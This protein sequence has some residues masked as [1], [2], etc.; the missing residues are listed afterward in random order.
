MALSLCIGGVIERSE[1]MH[2]MPQEFS[3][4]WMAMTFLMIV[5]VLLGMVMDPFGAVILVSAT[6][7]PGTADDIGTLTVQGN[8]IGAGGMLQTRVAGTP[9]APV[10][11]VLQISGAGNTASGSTGVSVIDAANF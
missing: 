4:V 9:Q 8:Y 7:A 5:K 10:A 2:L 3:S 6:I 11:D 1:V